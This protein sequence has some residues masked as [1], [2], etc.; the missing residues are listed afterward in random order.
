MNGLELFESNLPKALIHGDL[1]LDNVFADG[2]SVTAVFDF[3][4]VEYSYRILD[5]ARSCLSLAYAGSL[6]DEEI[7]RALWCGYDERTRL[8]DNPCREGSLSRCVAIRYCCLRSM[9]LCQRRCLVCR[10]LP[11]CPGSMEYGGSLV[12]LGLPNVVFKPQSL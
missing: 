3:E 12:A 10:P 6:D 5:V 9:A 7:L 11:G 2:E 8:A 4:T 1:M